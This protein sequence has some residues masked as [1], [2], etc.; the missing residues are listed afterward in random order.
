[1][2]SE[3][4]LATNA[5]A[6]CRHSNFMILLGTCLNGMGILVGGVAGRV[7]RRPFEP[8]TQGNLRTGLGIILVFAGLHLTWSH[9]GGGFLTVLKQFGIVMI[10][11]SLG[12]LIGKITRLQKTSNRLDRKSTRLNSSHPRLSRMPSSA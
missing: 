2:Q 9:F 1:M 5:L 7:M 12:N 8:S 3:V 4:A 11:M 10:S 6:R